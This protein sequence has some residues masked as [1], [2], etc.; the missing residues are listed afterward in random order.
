M[1]VR[2]PDAG[3]LSKLVGFDLDLVG[4]LASGSQNKH[5]GPVTRIIA[6]LLDVHK[7]WQQESTGLTGS[8]LSNGDEVSTFHSNGPG[9]RLDRGWLCEAR[10]F[11]LHTMIAFDNITPC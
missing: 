9:L 10:M 6:S 2:V 7:T 8:G 11:N 1:S 3:E 5:G 4:E